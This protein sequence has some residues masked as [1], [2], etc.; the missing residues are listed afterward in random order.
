MGHLGKLDL[1]EGLHLDCRTGPFMEE[2]GWKHGCGRPSP[3]SQLTR[4]GC[5]WWV[6]L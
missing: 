3:P 4:K 6:C 2:L 5:S 1:L